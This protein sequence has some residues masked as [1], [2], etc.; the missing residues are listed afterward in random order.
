MMF[1]DGFGFERYVEWLL[2]VPMYFVLR[3][4]VYHDVAG[5]SFRQYMTTGLPDLPGETA[6]LGDFADHM[7]T[8]FTDVRVK[9]FLEMRGAD[10]GQPGHD[11][12]SERI[13]DRVAV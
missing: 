5:Q 7:T 11:A 4:G 8:A 9:R 3:D 6:T 13:L 1:E 10:A 12:G 2:D